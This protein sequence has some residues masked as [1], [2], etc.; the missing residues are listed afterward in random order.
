MNYR[1]KIKG[2][3]V[4]QDASLAILKVSLPDRIMRRVLW[5]VAQSQ[6]NPFGL[7]SVYKVKRKL[8]RRKITLSG[9]VEGWESVLDS[10]EEGELRSLLR[11]MDELRKTRFHRSVIPLEGQFKIPILMMFGDGSREACCSLV[12]L[13]WERND[14]QV[15]C[16]LVTGKTQVTP[17]VKITIPGMELMAAVNS[18]RLA[19]KVRE[20]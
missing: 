14:S 11:D 12:Y 5:R 3:Y 9:K 16:R 2:A 19:R 1:D 18:V 7:L 6:Y 4:E 8:L 17:K 13:R 10:E 20:C 15:V